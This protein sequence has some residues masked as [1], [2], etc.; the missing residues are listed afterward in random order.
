MNDIAVMTELLPR[1]TVRL[2]ARNN[3]FSIASIKASYPNRLMLIEGF[4]IYSLRAVEAAFFPG[5]K[6]HPKPRPYLRGRGLPSLSQELSNYLKIR[7]LE[8]V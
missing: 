5:E 2:L 8:D 7:R 1:R 6:H 3:I 4:G